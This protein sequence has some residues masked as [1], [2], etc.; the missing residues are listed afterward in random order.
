M[1]KGKINYLGNAVET[2]VR[3]FV[4]ILGGAKVAD[5]LN[6]ISNLLEK[7]DTL[8][9]GGGMAYTF[10]KAHRAR[11]LVF[12]SLTHKDRLLQGK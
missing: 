5:K 11:K 7:C 4:A 12:P 3:P 9:I 6:V 2:P 1:Q 8:I 10:L